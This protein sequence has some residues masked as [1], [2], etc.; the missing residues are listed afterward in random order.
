MF[1]KELTWKGKHQGRVCFRLFLKLQANSSE[2]FYLNYLK[3][4]LFL[5][6]SV[7]YYKIIVFWGSYLVLASSSNHNTVI[8]LVLTVSQIR[9]LFLPQICPLLFYSLKYFLFFTYYHPHIYAYSNHDW[10]NQDEMVMCVCGNAV[11]KK[12]TIFLLVNS[13]LLIY[14]ILIL[15]KYNKNTKQRCK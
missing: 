12:C 6:F 5:W 8:N 4:P 3:I 1:G 15:Q 11:W 13:C 2:N 14:I 10:T 9:K 7:F